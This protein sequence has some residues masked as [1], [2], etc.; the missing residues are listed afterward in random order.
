MKM[1]SK[2]MVAA[3]CVL[4][5]LGVVL[6]P[7][8][9]VSAQEALPMGGL[10]SSLMPGLGAGGGRQ[11]AEEAEARLST[12]EVLAEDARSRTAFAGYKRDAAV[13]LAKRV[14]GVEYPHWTPPQDQGS[15]K[16]TKYVGRNMAEELLP[17]GS[18]VL[19][20]S[21]LPL[22]SAIGSG[23][24]KP[25]SLDLGSTG[26][27]YVPANPL[28][29]V[30][31]GKTLGEGVSFQGGLRMSPVEQAAPEA[32]EVVGDSVFYPGT[33]D[34]DFILEPRPL[35]VEASW[36]LL[37]AE[38]SSEN[39]LSFS[40]PQGAKLIMSK[41]LEGAA[42]V[43]LE[44]ETLLVIMPAS[45][46]TANGA[47]LPVSYSVN[48]STLTTHVDLS[49]NV[50]FPVDVDPV[51]WQS[52]GGGSG[53][54]AGWVNAA[55]QPGVAKFLGGP[56][57]SGIGAEIVAEAPGGS[58][59]TWGLYAPGFKA[60]EGALTR[61]DVTGM[62]HLAEEH[63]SE[64]ESGIVGR[65]NS[66]LP[67]TS[68]SYDGEIPGDTR[69]GMLKVSEKFEDRP[70][71]FCAQEE[72]EGYDRGP[73]PLCNESVGGEYFRFTI[74]TWERQRYWQ[75]E[76]IEANTARFIDTSKIEA[77]PSTAA[78]VDGTTNV[79][80]GSEK[81]FGPNNGALEIMGT[82]PAF[83]VSKLE[84]T[85]EGGGKSSSV[86]REYAKEGYCT[87]ILCVSEEKQMLTY[88]S[89]PAG[90]PN[91]VDKITIEASDAS[92]LEA[93]WSSSVD[94][95]AEAPSKPTVSGADVHEKEVNITEGPAGD[96]ITVE[97]AD[98]EG[99][100][101]S[102]GIKHLGIW[103]DGIQH[104]G[105][106]GS[107]S[108][109][110]CT[111]KA[112]WTLNGRELG[113]GNHKLTV[114]A[115]DN[116]DNE[117]LSEYEL[118]VH[119]AQPV[120]MGPG[121]VNPQSGDFALESAPVDLKAASGALTVT[122]HYDSRN[123]TEGAEGTL[124]PQ[125]TIGLGQ[126]AM[127]EVRGEENEKLE[128]I[129][130][131]M[132]DGP[133]GLSFFN[134]A[135]HGTFTSAENPELT[136]TLA[137]SDKEFILE[138]KKTGNST[139]FT[140]PKGA[141]H[142]M[143]TVSKASGK[144]NILTD[145]YQS[146]EVEKGRFIVK[147]TEELAPHGEAECPS[148][149]E[150]LKADKETQARAC[151]ALFFY[152]GGEKATQSEASGEKESQWGW[153]PNQL[154]R[155][156]AV[157]W[158]TS[159]GKME[160]TAVAEFSYD[161]KGRLR[162]EWDPRITPALK[163][164]Y[165]YDEEG[166]V[167]SLTSPGEQPWVFTYGTTAE[168]GSSGRLLKVRRAQPQKGASKKEIEER[169]SEERTPLE[170][171]ESIAISGTQAV[172]VQLSVSDGKW[173]GAPV[174]YAYQWSRCNASF[175]DCE[176]IPGAT[177]Q[178][179]TPVSADVNHI[180]KAQVTAINI[181]GAFAV[182]TK[183]GPLVSATASAYVSHSESVDSSSISGVSCIPGTTDCVVSDS[184]GN[185]LYAT[186][187]SSKAAASW[188]SWSGPGVS[189]SEAVDCPSSGLCL[190]AAGS[191]DDGAG[192]LYYATSL[193]G[194]W[195]EAYSP[196]YGVDTIACVSSSLC[197]DGQDADG[198]LRASTKPA[199]TS[200]SL[201]TQG[202]A[203][204]SA[205]ACLSSSFCVLAD[206]AGRVHVAT[207]ASKIESGSW[208]E[209]DVDGSA[210]LTGVACVST[211][212]CLAVDGT[213]NVLQLNIGETGAVSSTGKSDI[214]GTNGLTAISC[215]S[216]VCAAVDSK[217]N[218]LVTA[219]GG[220]S[221]SKPWALG[222]DLTSISCASKTLCAT[223]S[224]SGQTTAFNPTEE[225]SEG[226][227]DSPQTGAT[228]EYDV[229]VSGPGAPYAMSAAKV[230]QW[231]QKD[232]PVEAAET[233]PE[234]H[235][236]GWPASGHTGAT[237]YYTDNEAQTVNV[238]NPSGG[239]A[240]TEY[241][242]GDMVRA[243]SADNGERALKEAD[244]VE[245]ASKLATISKYSAENGE[246][247]EVTGPEHKVKLS[248]GEEVEARNQV[249]YFYGEGAPENSKGEVEEYGLV[250]K[251]TD[252]A[253]LGDGEEK[254][255]RTTL[256]GY[257]GEKGEG[258]T[259]RAPTSTTTEP[260]GV[261][262]VSS[263][264]YNKET[265]A[266]EETRTPGGNAETV[267]PPE[268][269]E[270]FGKYGSGS[271]QMNE[272]VDTAVGPE[273]DVYV[274]DQENKRIEKFT[275]SGAFVEAFTVPSADKELNNP[276]QIAIGANGD[277]YIADTTNNRVVVLNKEGKFVEA[278]THPDLPAKEEGEVTE[279]VALDAPVGIAVTP[280]GNVFVSNYSSNEVLELNEAGKLEASFGG[281]GAIG[282]KGSGAGKFEGP[283]LLAFSEGV[284]Y[285]ADTG[286]KR[287]E[288]FSTA[289]GGYIGQ[290]GSAGTGEG[291]FEDPSGIAVAPAT[292][293]LYVSDEDENRVQQ[294][295]P[296]GKFL[297]SFG[298]WGSEN[299]A[300]KEPEGL[301][302][303]TS[304]K[305]YV[306]DTGNN[307]V[308]VWSLPETAG[309]HETYSTQFGAAGAG[310]GE[311]EYAAAPAVTP[312]GHVLVTD[313]TTNLIQEFSS[314]GKYLAS[315]G[316]TGE[317]AGKFEEATGIAV[318]Q[319][320]GDM[321]VGDCGAHS[322][323]ELNAKGEYIRSLTSSHLQCPGEIAIDSSG[324]VWTAD[325]SADQVEEFSE[326]GSFLHV[327]GEKGEGDLQFNDPAGII[328]ANKDIY[329]ADS[330][331]NR[332]QVMSTS[333]AYIGQFG[334]QGTQGGEFE[335]PEGLAADAAGDVF[336][337][338]SGNNRI[339]E[340][341]PTDKYI[342]SIGTHGIAEGQLNG[343]QGIAVTAA[344][345]IYVTDAQNHRVERWIPAAQA[346]H[347]TKTIY[348]TPEKEAGI[349]ACENK[350]QWAGLVCQTE[351]LAQ[352][353]DSS[354]EPKG[355]ELPR[356][357]VI[358][359]EYNMWLQP[360]KSIETIGSKTRTKTTTYEGERVTEQSVEAGAGKT[361]YPVHD[362]YSSTLGVLVEQSQETEHEG[363]KT[364]TEVFNSLGQL[365]S[366]TD[367]EG[368]AT[369]YSYDQ[370]G[371]PTE[372]NYDASK[373]DHLA[374]REQL[375]Y[376]ETTGE[377]AEIEDLGGEGTY[378]G[379]G[380]GAYKASYGPEGELD[381]ETYPNNMTAT[382]GYNS[383][384]EGTSLTYKKNNHC[385]GSEC[386][387]FTD[388][389]TPSVHGEAMLQKS[390]LASEQYRYEQPGRLAEVKETPAGEDCTARI[391]AQNEEGAR[392][393]L[394]TRKSGS[395]E[396]TAT[397]GGEVER[398][399]Y[400]EANRNT[401]EGVKY[402]PLGNITKLPAADAGGH[403]LTTEYYTNSQ[404]QR[405]TQ[406]ETTNNYLYDPEGRTS[407]TETIVEALV[408]PTA[409]ITIAH[410]PGTGSTAPSWAYNQTAG[411]ITRNVA[412]FGGLAA[413]EE[414]G[415]EPLLQIHDLLG[416]IVG[417]AALSE[418]ASKS[419]T[420]ERTTEYGV[421]TKEKP[422]DKYNWLGTADIASD[423]SSGTVVQDGVTYVPQLG[424]PLTVEGVSIPAAP[425]TAAPY[426]VTASPT[427]YANSEPWAPESDPCK[428]AFLN[429][430]LED[431]GSKP[432]LTA[433]ATVEFC[434]ANEIIHSH[435][436]VNEG[437]HVYNEHLPVYLVGEWEFVKAEHRY[438]NW[439]D[440]GWYVIWL[441]D[442]QYTIPIASSLGDV[443]SFS[444]KATAWISLDFEEYGDGKFED[445][446][447]DG[448]GLAI[449]QP[450]CDLIKCGSN[451]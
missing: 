314:Q 360:V 425:L 244:P 93:I 451:W 222:G 256:T 169:L 363:T 162:A 436:T 374:D 76:M 306:A 438:G 442:F 221:W 316:G 78:E 11:A 368:N 407:Q 204:M 395:G 184:K 246:L 206:S 207:S 247:S 386:E 375:R 401:D 273:G 364:I 234:E 200:W 369:T 124:G 122:Q 12:P 385:T 173:S 137:S 276:N 286:N 403:E 400:D 210:A 393:S 123:V 95:D 103:I 295:S 289:N 300:V 18:H 128:K 179:Y 227:H 225:L 157:V 174:A 13:A 212:S 167:T 341:S 75:Y 321:Y 191:S 34:T 398:H 380:T 274:V 444:V 90:I 294:F 148:E 94:V 331:N 229:P 39:A 428:R 198:Y 29:P 413:V 429:D 217:G 172:G 58:W 97:A 359:I 185:E 291:Q 85:I 215:S 66:V 430:Q 362:K 35:G 118:E 254:D 320:T 361:V 231:G 419:H 335:H 337:L 143:P 64:I 309:L 435:N 31:L 440:N 28:V 36:Q 283:G 404:V 280:G 312:L 292:G 216:S 285:V 149:R 260:D 408:K 187:V 344:D 26:P 249:R 439:D 388:T 186:N 367:A 319:A 252:G 127:L 397:E 396:C 218:V 14:F 259:L 213:G 119:A 41:T 92:G 427:W 432:V 102:A 108:R 161:K 19:V 156:V 449:D 199:S 193:G 342:Q 352:P 125:W 211:S 365:E 178:N 268:A 329:V 339:Q 351:P 155:V 258:W 114:K 86:T 24:E 192:N 142:W 257:S 415:K 443:I 170:N 120:A 175:E 265:G 379:K 195:S 266:V 134:P 168:D 107:C 350:P 332:V 37:S 406:N 333:G 6:A 67:Y 383:I 65:E 330:K 104:E 83:G 153:Y 394:T 262:L 182:A 181:N 154:S 164:V 109:G 281:K 282:G 434:Y 343:P 30:V 51:V 88:N 418:T 269:K 378:E 446:A 287:V 236:Q 318:N 80:A 208:T 45:A 334:S 136:L 98:G 33:K 9:A 77:K 152:Y 238:A 87:G 53:F 232:D 69:K 47:R 165:G 336:V 297:A 139:V 303:S 431:G 279:G 99:S 101:T 25:V 377:L 141:K 209:T 347:D 121:S 340:F 96:Q 38:S 201:T 382:Y 115:L 322:I 357:P 150:A 224:T 240:T 42:E 313:A 126:L 196:A 163:T 327:Y 214:D 81:W 60:G 420:L 354:A 248:D 1:L 89:F 437:E 56:G 301:S 450:L 46:A 391:Y 100:V 10:E 50:D 166:H 426:V 106:E 277:M 133:E 239:I 293:D 241:H 62:M 409:S 5:V 228:I 105:Y 112:T 346:V 328:Y 358:R 113:A 278:W 384:G 144:T 275:S 135:E 237:V 372:V 220:S 315:Y 176:V 190:L 84:V 402:E 271:G 110:P 416:N 226:A 288:K 223:A 270:P 284:L 245:A 32:A 49:G 311:F 82:D 267:S 324:N 392:T 91:G 376:E 151:R 349:E 243:L 203:K 159:A 146:V 55:S 305:L 421:P 20:D 52:Y 3:A 308:S 21:S 194:A 417:T 59:A 4:C 23:E 296:A 74:F 230:E 405:Q 40:L 158:S 263:T 183:G 307:R 422:E 298:Y 371:R 445:Q 326:T 448:K 138:N 27:G 325:M 387:W 250:T 117:S 140:H 79:L 219:N 48:G 17:D 7:A 414:A 399:T 441:F 272:P 373:L 345:D 63:K 16:I 129:E 61:M 130:D 54:W 348:Y 338:D 205:A 8:E 299:A 356:L 71:A 70:V 355:E 242:E 390:N 433:W 197:V 202:T 131:V 235:A 255:V 189:P 177:N 251:T 317:S 381:S 57:N 22:R 389:L 410:Y 111:A 302:I 171:S 261:D 73:K 233:F 15:G 370:Y 188:S 323:Q 290:F 304:G 424:R 132:V 68:Y 264:K 43:T 116:A 44:G 2:L 366:Y 423:L 180:L 160:E 147:P 447:N 72:P 411:T 145:S 412:A 353:T 253:L 310:P